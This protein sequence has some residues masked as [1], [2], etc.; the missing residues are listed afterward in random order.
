MAIYV[1]QR[2]VYKF[3]FFVNKRNLLHSKLNPSSPSST[4]CLFGSSIVLP[5][6]VTGKSRAVIGN[7]FLVVFWAM[8]G[9]Q[10]SVTS[11][12][13]QLS[14]FGVIINYCSPFKWSFQLQVSEAG[15]LAGSRSCGLAE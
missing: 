7:A 12:K 8:G 11:I 6:Y 5:P 15:S 4:L 9:L 2:I 14:Y 13:N 1:Q 3:E 10:P